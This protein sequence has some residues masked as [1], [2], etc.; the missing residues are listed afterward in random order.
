MMGKKRRFNAEWL[1]ARRDSQRPGFTTEAQRAL[2]SSRAANSLK[3]LFNSREEEGW[4]R[5]LGE[6]GEQPKRKQ[7]LPGQVRYQAGAW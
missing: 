4:P 6:H 2:R 5:G 7:E 1:R 3:R